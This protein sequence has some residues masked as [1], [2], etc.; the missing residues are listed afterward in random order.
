MTFDMSYLRNLFL[1]GLPLRHFFP[2]AR[3]PFDF[4]RTVVGES[5]LVAVDLGGRGDIQPCWLALDGVAQVHAFEP[6]GLATPAMR[7]NFDA[8]GNGS[9][10]VIHDVGVTE[11]G[12]E[13]TLYV[14]GPAS[15][16]SVYPMRGQLY[17]RYGNIDDSKTRE[18]P[19]TTVRL[20]DVLDRAGVERV[21]MIKLDIQGAELEVLRSLRAERIAGLDCIEAEALVPAD[22]IR[23]PLVSYLEFFRDNG[24]DVYDVRSHRAPIV[25][26]DGV[27][28][29]GRSFG[30]LRPALSIAERLWE[31]DFV[32]F[33]SLDEILA[34]GDPAR[35]RT[36]IASLC[37]YNYFGEA[38]WLAKAPQ[39]E[40]LLGIDAQRLQEAIIAWHAKLRRH[41]LDRDFPGAAKIIWLMK[42]LRIGNRL[43]WARSQWVGHP[44]A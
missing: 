37:T 7:A 19:I 1:S 8:R 30:T 13:R 32:A 27:I 10:Y 31:F 18:V 21:A 34:S 22:N 3:T 14:N 6:D 4:V 44:S 12:G 33:R 20:D 38:M 28:E 5:Q 42:A 15:G 23:P 43:R 2:R 36:M 29:H 39:A 24:F 17:E 9:H 41:L 11:T 16:A 35:V 26:A 40:E 25:A